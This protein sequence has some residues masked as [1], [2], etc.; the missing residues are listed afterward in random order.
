[1]TTGHRRHRVAAMVLLLAL[2]APLGALGQAASPQTALV[3]RS[4]SQEA[5]PAN[6]GP[7]WADDAVCYEVLVRSFAD[8]DGDDVG[9]LNGLTQKLNYVND[10]DPAT[11][12]DLGVTCLWLMPIFQAT[13]YHGYDV[14]DFERVDPDYGTNEDFERLVAEAHRRGIRVILDLVLNHTSRN[15][16]WFQEALNDPA[17]P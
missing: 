17:S 9:D 14:E 12:T 3:N 1:M 4:V 13:S 5:T 2:L 10:G 15:H 8:S 16:P 7:A 11:T 6:A